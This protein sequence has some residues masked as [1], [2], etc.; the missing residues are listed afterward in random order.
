[1]ITMDQ[2]APQDMGVTKPDNGV[3]FSDHRALERSRVREGG[4]RTSLFYY[5]VCQSRQ[6]SGCEGNH[7]ETRKILLKDENMSFNALSAEEC[8]LLMRHVNSEQRSSLGTLSL[9][10]MPK[11]SHK[12]LADKLL[13]YLGAKRFRQMN[14][15]DTCLINE[16]YF[17]RGD[18]PL[19]KQKRSLK[20]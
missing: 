20:K 14:W 5:D 16:T 8:S 6:K 2:N 15:P 11:A 17:K 13:G 10:R 4:R 7:V 9:I 12:D 18:E 3:E 1:M 19:V